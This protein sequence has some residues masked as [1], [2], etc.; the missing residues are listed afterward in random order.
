ML[1]NPINVKRFIFSNV[2]IYDKYKLIKN[3]VAI[4]ETIW[5]KTFIE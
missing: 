2:I 3:Y 1:K 4:G 5:R